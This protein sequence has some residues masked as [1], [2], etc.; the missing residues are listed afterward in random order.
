MLW[1]PSLF[2]NIITHIFLDSYCEKPCNY[3]LK[4]KIDKCTRQEKSSK[5]DLHNSRPP[6]F[7]SNK[8]E[9]RKN[10]YNYRNVFSIRPAK[11]ASW[12][13]A[14]GQSHSSFFPDGFWEALID[15]WLAAW[16]I[17][18]LLIIQYYPQP[19]SKYLNMGKCLNN[20]HR[21]TATLSMLV[22]VKSAK[23][24]QSI[25]ASDWLMK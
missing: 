3:T 13:A 4:P 23:I 20:F 11:L 14:W 10:V 22:S 16:K 6:V 19:Q 8:R 9:H 2:P 17:E 1:L 12:L 24:R 18:I 7:S 15:G 25:L 21:W 5:H